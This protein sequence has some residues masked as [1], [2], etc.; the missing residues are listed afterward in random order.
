MKSNLNKV[1]KL[2][3]GGELKDD[4]W[5]KFLGK[6][7]KRGDSCIRVRIPAKY[8]ARTMGNGP[9]DRQDVG[10]RREHFGDGGESHVRSQREEDTDER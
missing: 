2:K 8:Y 3:W 4:E 1:F 5:V 10:L 9:L 7:W 6:E